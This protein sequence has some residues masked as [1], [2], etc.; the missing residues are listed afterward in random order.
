MVRIDRVTVGDAMPCIAGS[1]TVYGKNMMGKILMNV[2]RHDTDYQNHFPELPRVTK[3][4]S[5]KACHA[6]A[7]VSTP[8]PHRQPKVL[9]IGNSNANGLSQGLIDCVVDSTGSVYLGQSI[10]R[11]RDNVRHSQVRSDVILL[12]AGDIKIQNDSTPVESIITDMKN[13]LLLHRTNRCPNALRTA[14]ML[15]LGSVRTMQTFCTLAT[16]KL[17]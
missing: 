16:R 5:S 11:I 3:R 2:R 1:D 15:W 7:E 4:P 12:G 10:N 13:F 14:T 6:A 8:H 17:S 9:V